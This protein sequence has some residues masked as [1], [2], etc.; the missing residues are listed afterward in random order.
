MIIRGDH[1]G[2]VHGFAHQ[3]YDEDL[4][5]SVWGRGEGNLCSFRCQDKKFVVIEGKLLTEPEVYLSRN[6]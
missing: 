1:E 2:D 3:R 4:M 5:D 6:V